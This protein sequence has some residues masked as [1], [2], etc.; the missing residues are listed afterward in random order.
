MNAG[1]EILLG[2]MESHPE[3]FQW[4]NGTARWSWVLRMMAGDKNAV[5]SAPWGYD[6]SFLPPEEL[7]ALRSKLHSIQG[8]AFT[9]SVMRELLVDDEVD[10]YP[11]GRGLAPLKQEGGSYDPLAPIRRSPTSPKSAAQL[12]AKARALGI[13][14]PEA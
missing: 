2:R 6:L 1:V 4:D 12:L 3:E 13:T 10:K 11:L 9:R 7:R 8:E 5:N 14:N